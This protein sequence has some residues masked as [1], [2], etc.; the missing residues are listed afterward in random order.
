VFPEDTERR[1]DVERAHRRDRGGVAALH[2]ES[3]EPQVAQAT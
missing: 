3:R 1:E 2:A